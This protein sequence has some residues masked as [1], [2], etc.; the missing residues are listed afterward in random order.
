MSDISVVVPV[1][2]N[3]VY[4]QWL[5]ECIDSL[6]SQ[7]QLPSEII[8][9]DDGANLQETIAD[10]FPYEKY[11]DGWKGSQITKLYRGMDGMPDVVYYK[12]L[13]K[14]GVSNAFNFGISLSTSSLVFMVGSD[15]RLLPGCLEAV[16]QSYED[17]K[18]KAG[19]YNVTTITEGGEVSWIPNNAAAVTKGLWKWLGGFPPSAGLGACDALALSILMVHAPD[20]IIQVKQH[21]PLCWLRE[22]PDQDTRI[23]GWQFGEEIIS[24]RNKETRRF[25]PYTGAIDG[26]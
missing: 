10:Y 12:T 20:R 19:W 2:P 26:D 13:W 21:T 16:V 1:G 8:I 11:S 25:K 22:H 23:N 15:D 4:L 3:P 5:P 17:H 9:I 24:V 14:A 7:S 6:L 18:E